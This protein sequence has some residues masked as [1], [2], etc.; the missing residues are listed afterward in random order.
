MPFIA[1]KCQAYHPHGRG[2]MVK[3]DIMSPFRSVSPTRAGL[4]VGFKV[5]LFHFEKYHPHGR[6]LMLAGYREL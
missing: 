5:E 3:G 4:N 1:N 2:L 6:G